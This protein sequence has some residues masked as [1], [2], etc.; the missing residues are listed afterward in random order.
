MSENDP[1]IKAEW[2]QQRHAATAMR[3]VGLRELQDDVAEEFARGVYNRL[4]CRIG[5]VMVAA[6]LAALFGFVL[7]EILTEPDVGT[8]FRVGLAAVIIG[9]ALLISG[10]WRCRRRVARKDPYRE[11]IR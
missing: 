3:S 7:Y 4:E 10:V 5:W 9:F 1:E 2:E 8:V 6:G 11:V